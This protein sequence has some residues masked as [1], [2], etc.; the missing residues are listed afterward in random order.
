VLGQLLI[1]IAWLSFGIVLFLL[2][3]HFY[4][5]VLSSQRWGSRLLGDPGGGERFYR[6]AAMIVVAIVSVAA[7]L[8]GV[9]ALYEGLTG[10]DFP[11]DYSRLWDLWPTRD[12]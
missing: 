11:L 10:R 2:R 1:G 8:A 5:G 7:C 9:Q 6:P 4:E 12:R 3:E